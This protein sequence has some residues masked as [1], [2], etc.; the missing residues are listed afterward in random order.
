[1]VA[2]SS[3]SSGMRNFAESGDGSDFG[4]SSRLESQPPAPHA[5][6]HP[7]PSR[8][9]WHGGLLYSVWEVRTNFLDSLGD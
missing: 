9:C 5:Q 7:V 4:R 2:H 3:L 8:V 6:Q 1:M